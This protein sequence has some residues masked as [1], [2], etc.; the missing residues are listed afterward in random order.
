MLRHTKGGNTMTDN[1]KLDLLLTGMMLS[2]KVHMLEIDM[3]DVKA[4][5]A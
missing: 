5:L 3:R 1:Q 2:L 4:K